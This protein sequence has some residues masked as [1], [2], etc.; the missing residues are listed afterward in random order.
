MLYTMMEN[1]KE[2][3][4]L[5]MSE[6]IFSPVQVENF[7]PNSY[8]KVLFDLVTQNSFPWYYHESISGI[9]NLDQFSQDNLQYGFA[10]IAYSNDEAYEFSKTFYPMIFFIEEKFN[11]PVEKLLRIRLGLNLRKTD[12]NVVHG[13]HVDYQ[14]P[15]KTLLYYVNDSDGDTIF[16]DKFF[17]INDMS[18]NSVDFSEMKIEKTV[19]P[20][21]NRAIVFDG[22]QYHSS[23][24]P[25]KYVKR[26]AINI[27]F[28]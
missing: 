17:E 6:N 7:L 21:Q 12:K 26:I 3:K 25:S 16:Y 20:K 4:I 13:P 27:N 1:L 15:H 24:S 8:Q 2:R 9:D 19:S 5:T 11:I 28:I 22:L 14:V 23:S 10:H 18:K